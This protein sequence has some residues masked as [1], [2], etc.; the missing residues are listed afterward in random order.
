MPYI[1]NGMDRFNKLSILLILLY[2]LMLDLLTSTKI[3]N[4]RYD[5]S[6]DDFVKLANAPTSE[7][8]MIRVPTS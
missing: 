3:C 5:L 4:G 8:R 2:L 6:F 7:N 1:P